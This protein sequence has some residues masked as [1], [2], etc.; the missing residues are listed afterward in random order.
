MDTLQQI[1]SNKTRFPSPPQICLKVLEIIQDENF[2]LH[3]LAQVI[4]A[5]PSLSANLLRVAN[6]PHY[7][8][9][10]HISSVEK[11]VAVLGVNAVKIIALSF[12]AYTEFQTDTANS[13]ESDLFWRRALTS[14][15]AAE[16][17]SLSQG[18]SSGDIFLI[19]LLQD[20]GC[21]MIN[22]WR[23][24]EYRNLIK[25]IGDDTSSQLKLEQELFGFDHS[26]IGSELLKSW[27]YPEELYMPLRFH[28]SRDTAPLHYRT[29]IHILE[30][31]NL[32]SAFYNDNHNA[33]KIKLAKQILHNNLGIEE[34][35]LEHLIDSIALKSRE[36]LSAFEISDG[37]M[38][39]LSLILQEA[40]EELGSLYDSYELLL[41]EL[42]QAKEK[43]EDLIQDL[44]VANERLQ[45]LVYVDELTQIYNLRFFREAL[46]RELARSNRYGR[47]LSLVIF[48]ID[49]LKVIND[50]HGHLAGS[51]VLVNYSR[52]V[53][54]N[55]RSTD[56]FARLGGDEFGILLPETNSTS[57]CIVAEQIRHAI[58]LSR[59]NLP[60]TISVGVASVSSKEEYSDPKLIFHLA[61]EALSSAKKNGKNCIKVG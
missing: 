2:T 46:E 29:H 32:L 54:A 49:N 30:A 20:I 50:T 35:A 28:H 31:A 4:S 11:A 44:Q 16:Q 22:N 61:D 51:Q 12:V 8:H 48:D 19:A 33:V 59:Q 34:H 55:L 24:Q 52:I 36:M 40:N 6:T 27:N 39:P 57:A 10:G 1:I 41:L 60:T 3:D 15:V 5:D 14:A 21:L 58:D 13:F 47:E 43:N 25:S 37:N 26:T 45:E 23:P 7:N 17:I 53:Q 42:K 18:G 56:V 38:K 9:S